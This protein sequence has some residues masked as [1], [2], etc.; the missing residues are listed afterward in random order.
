M[1]SEK[2]GISLIG[3]GRKGVLS[4]IFSR[5]GLVILLLAVQLLALVVM[6][7]KLQEY[8]VHFY[9]LTIV[10]SV[11]MVVH[12]LNSR[13]DATSKLTWI[14][15]IMILPVFGVLLYFFVKRDL[16]H[17]ALMRRSREISDMTRGMIPQDPEIPGELEEKDPGAAGLARY[18]LRNADCPVH[19]GVEVTYF[20]D[21]SDKFR[22]MLN[23]LEKAEKFIYLEY[24]II[25]EGE[26]WG[27]RSK[28]SPAR[29]RRAWT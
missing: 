17:R 4:V 28:S 9:G 2:K 8:L 24:F 3:K 23:E 27:R 12:L 19:K 25:A 1:N 11:L 29:R 7:G 15:I 21:G 6:Y 13:A 18:L 20:P 26:M 10:F 14:T 16:G 22:A 5:A